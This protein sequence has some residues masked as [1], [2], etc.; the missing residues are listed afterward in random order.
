[1][2]NLKPLNMVLTLMNSQKC[3]HTL[4]SKQS[5]RQVKS[6]TSRMTRRNADS[7]R[8]HGTTNSLAVHAVVRIHSQISLPTKDPQMNLLWGWSWGNANK[9]QGIFTGRILGWVNGIN[10]AGIW[11]SCWW[12]CQWAWSVLLWSI[13]VKPKWRNYQLQPIAVRFNR[14][15]LQILVRNLFKIIFLKLS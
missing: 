8:T 14:H 6:W 11:F 9:S 13:G 12:L 7:A 5:W 10:L 1:M 2:K 3:S 4:L 15:G